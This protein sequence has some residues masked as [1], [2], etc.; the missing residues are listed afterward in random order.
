[1]HQSRKRPSDTVIRVAPISHKQ[2]PNYRSDTGLTAKA[3]ECEAA[4][5]LC[6][7]NSP[8]LRMTYHAAG[9]LLQGGAAALL[10]VCW[11]LLWR[12]GFGSGTGCGR[13]VGGGGVGDV[14]REQK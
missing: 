11:L 10:S 5:V 6:D 8:Q 12:G 9:E 14:V 2:T 1:M 4:S 13:G 3:T 7:M